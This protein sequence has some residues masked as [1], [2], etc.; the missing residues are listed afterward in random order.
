[1]KI[2]TIQEQKSQ[3]KSIEIKLK[4]KKAEYTLHLKIL[5]LLVKAPKSHR[6]YRGC[7]HQVHLVVGLE[8]FTMQASLV[9]E[10]SSVLLVTPNQLEKLLA[11]ISEMELNMLNLHMMG[12]ENHSVNS[13]CC[14]LMP[15]SEK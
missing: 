4:K 8:L 9:N 1:M 14:Q 15:G 2:V 13:L 10:C 12:R 6:H 5:R 3:Q 7:I 11:F